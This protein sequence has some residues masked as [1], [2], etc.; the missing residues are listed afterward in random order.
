MPEERI[1]ATLNKKVTRWKGGVE[2][3]V[4]LLG[5]I[6]LSICC[7]AAL[8]LI[9][10]CFDHASRYGFDSVAVNKIGLVLV[11]LFQGFF[12]YILLKGG[13]E[14][15]RLLKKLNG[16]EFAGTISTPTP[17]MESV[18]SNCGNQLTYQV[19]SCWKCKAIFE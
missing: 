7:I 17:V 18:C 1:K 14:I 2:A 19:P 9:I 12:I 6:I 5:I 11:V 15:I 8:F 16:L 4:S 3:E 13:A 10:S